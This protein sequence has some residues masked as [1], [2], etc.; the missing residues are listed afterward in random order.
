MAEF[1][2]V[3]EPAHPRTTTATATERRPP[4]AATEGVHLDG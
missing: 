3:A 2:S 1:T 4:L